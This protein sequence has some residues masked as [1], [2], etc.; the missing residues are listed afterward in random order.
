MILTVDIGNT[1]TVCGVFAK[2]GNLLCKFRIQSIHD[3]TTDE[4]AVMLLS[5]LE[6]NDI[7]VKA[8]DG[9]IIASV[10]PQLQYIFNRVIHKYLNVKP[11]IVGSG[12]KTGIS[13]RVDNPKEVG[14]DRIANAAACLAGFEAPCVI[15]DMGT[16][17]TF[18]V[19]NASYDYIGGIICPGIMLASKMLRVNTAQLPEVSV[20]KPSSVVGKNTVQHIQSG[21]YFGYLEMINGLILRIIDEEFKDSGKVNVIVTGGMGHDISEGMKYDAIYEPNLTL[22]GLYAIYMRN[23]GF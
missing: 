8:I 19:L 12:V 6:R 2:D 17:T 14:A 18:D 16:A 11:L 4:Y 10:V 3:K 22:N 21:I 7:D 20:K 5:L 23:K 13:I 1:N 9:A 15:V